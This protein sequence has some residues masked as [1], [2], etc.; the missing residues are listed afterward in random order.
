MIKTSL[1]IA[2]IATAVFAQSACRDIY[3][4]CSTL[5]TEVGCCYGRKFGSGSSFTQGCCKSCKKVDS[6]AKCKEAARDDLTGR[7][8]LKTIK[9]DHKGPSHAVNGNHTCTKPEERKILD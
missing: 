5:V 8:G 6:S 7:E 3:S 1:A 4:N 9:F 2:Y